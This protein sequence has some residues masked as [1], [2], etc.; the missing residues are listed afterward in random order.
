MQLLLSS[1]T[2]HIPL[3]AVL[4]IGEFCDWS[5]DSKFLTSVNSQSAAESAMYSASVVLSDIK[6][7]ILDYHT[8]GQPVNM[9]TYPVLECDESMSLLDL[10]FRD[11]A[12]SAST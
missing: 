3:G 4:G 6:G 1:K 12:Q 8:I 9:M 10:S 11:P 2:L 5:S 7:F